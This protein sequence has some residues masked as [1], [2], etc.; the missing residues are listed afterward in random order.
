MERTKKAIKRIL[1][2]LLTGVSVLLVPHI[3]YW[4]YIWYVYLTCLLNET[5]P[6]LAEVYSFINSIVQEFADTGISGLLAGVIVYGI[7]KLTIIGSE[8]L[9]PSVLGGH[10][11]IAG[12]LSLLVVAWNFIPF[13]L[14]LKRLGFID[15]IQSVQGKILFFTLIAQLVYSAEILDTFSAMGTVKL[16]FG[17]RNRAVFLRLPKDEHD[18]FTPLAFIS[19]T[20]E[21]MECEGKPNYDIIYSYLSLALESGALGE[22]NDFLLCDAAL[23]RKSTVL[24]KDFIQIHVGSDRVYSNPNTSFCELL[25]ILAKHDSLP[26]TM[27]NVLELKLQ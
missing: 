18:S 24:L 15:G 27:S 4:F 9:H 23:V 7:C 20:K 2:W 25:R 17:N 19:D 1:S 3:V 21:L 5:F 12:I 10:F 22:N 6:I 16:L 13:V 11:F 26:C 8:K 14:I